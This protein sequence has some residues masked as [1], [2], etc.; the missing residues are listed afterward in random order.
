MFV[1]EAEHYIIQTVHAIKVHSSVNSIVHHRKTSRNFGENRTYKC[2]FL[3]GIQ[4][5]ILIH[6]GLWTKFT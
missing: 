3:P 1:C 5:I 2:T 6:Y 4:K